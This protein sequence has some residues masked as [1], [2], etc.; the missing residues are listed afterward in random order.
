MKRLKSRI[1]ALESGRSP[2]TELNAA[3]SSLLVNV[4]ARRDALFWLWRFQ[5][6]SK[7]SHPE[8]RRRQREYLAGTVG[9]AVRADGKADWKN[10]HDIRQRLIASGLITAVHSSG[11]VTGVFLTA[12]GEATARAMVGDRLHSFHESGVVVLAR[13]R[14]LSAATPVRA[15]RESVLWGRE[16]L[17]CPNS[18]DDFTET[19]LPCITAGLVTAD[20]DTQGR[21]CY[22]PVDGIPEPPEITVSVAADDALDELYLSSFH[23]E[24]QTLENVEP[25]DPH[26]ICIPLP[27]SGWGWEC[28]FKEKTSNEEI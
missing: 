2:S 16:L 25:R 6:H 24:R 9:V 28:Y 4:L 12:Q 3:E 19:I 7:I 15:V 21:A 11:Q 1:E 17:G 20:S 18:W 22:T 10:A 5:I 13:L 26:E 23:N 27:A 8:I 14:D